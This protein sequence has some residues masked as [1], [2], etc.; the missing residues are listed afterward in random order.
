MPSSTRQS[1][2]TATRRTQVA[3]GA[4]RGLSGDKGGSVARRFH[5]RLV[6]AAVH[7]G[8]KSLSQPD[9]HESG[10]TP[11]PSVRLAALVRL[12][13]RTPG[14]LGR[15]VCEVHIVAADQLGH[16][17]VARRALWAATAAAPANP[18]HA[19]MPNTANRTPIEMNEPLTRRL[20][21]DSRGGDMAPRWPR[22]T[23]LAFGHLASVHAL[24]RR[25]PTT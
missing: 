12:P 19:A 17:R 23:W 3:D 20:L 25:S 2:R 16:S 1:V 24:P 5:V 11:G 10:S 9:V 7:Q 18:T 8:D 4:S 13:I 22:A 14:A 21:G 6:R 15:G